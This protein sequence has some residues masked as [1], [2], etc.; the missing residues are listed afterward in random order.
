L[1]VPALRAELADLSAALR[2][3]VGEARSVV[4]AAFGP[5]RLLPEHLVPIDLRENPVG[6][7]LGEEALEGP[8]I[9]HLYAEFEN[10]A[11]RL[12]LAVGGAKTNLVAGGCNPNELRVRIK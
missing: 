4:Q 7:A 6:D 5:I 10:T 2:A 1:V 12:A 11:E 8:E 9:V 3:E